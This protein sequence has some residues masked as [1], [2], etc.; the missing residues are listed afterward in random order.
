[1]PLLGVADWRGFYPEGSATR[2][3]YPGGEKFCDK[4]WFLV[5]TE[6]GSSTLGD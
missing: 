5:N 4:W 3:I 1:M 2:N 6:L